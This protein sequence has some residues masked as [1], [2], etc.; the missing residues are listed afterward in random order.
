[1]ARGGGGGGCGRRR[2][3]FSSLGTRSSMLNSPPR[4]YEGSKALNRAALFEV[5][6]VIDPAESRHW[7]ASLM[8]SVRF[9]RRSPTVKRRPSVDAW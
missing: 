1:M 5:D 9:E 2:G 8:S 6:D 4:A 3:R 7:V